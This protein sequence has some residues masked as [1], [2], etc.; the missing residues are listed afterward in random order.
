ML[1][2]CLAESHLPKL[3]APTR[4]KVRDIYDL[5]SDLLIVTT[6]RISAFDVVL[7]CVPCK[8]QVLN[9]IA[10]W[11]FERS[12]H[13]VPNPVI[14]L[15]DPNAVLMRKLKA[16]PVEVIVRRHITGS[17]WREYAK[18]VREI[19]GL[20]LP[21]GL[22]AD[23]RFD[24][25][26]VTPTTKAEQ[27]E[28]DAPLSEAEIVERGLVD[29]DLWQE[30]RKAALSLFAAGEAMAA[31]RGLILVDTKYEFGLDG[32]R[33]MVMDEIHTPDSSRY[34]EAEGFSERMAAGQAQRMLDKEN[35]RQWL[36]ERDFDGHG[37]A[38]VLDE[39]IRLSL[40][41]T[42]V[43]LQERICGQTV[44]L[45]ELDPHTRLVSNLRAAGLL[46]A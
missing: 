21:D 6:D 4:G 35:L 44:N 36:L 5:G 16:L 3:P 24:E 34:W 46:P 27:G 13:L 19:Y 15:P 28:H 20:R 42:Y 29:G 10:A 17:L 1:D 8:G 38:P 37:P 23:S 26:I 12:A 14:S 7:G 25:A 41:Q 40:A 2:R 18:G 9:T 32:D 22:L 45:P 33:L 31:K 11:G 43:N 30:V 39:A